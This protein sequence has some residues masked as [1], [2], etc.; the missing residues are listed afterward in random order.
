MVR[1]DELPPD[2]GAS[3]GVPEIGA[4]TAAHPIL[5]PGKF[6][7][8]EVDAKGEAQRVGR[9]APHISHAPA[10]RYGSSMADGANVS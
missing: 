1:W 10:F 2:Q 8:W 7:A 5:L 3:E 6:A 4:I 9:S